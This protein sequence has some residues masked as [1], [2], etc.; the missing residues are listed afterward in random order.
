MS[1]TKLQPTALR[2]CCR[3]QA[4]SKYSHLVDASLGKTERRKEIQKLIEKNR[5]K[6]CRPPTQVSRS[7]DEL[8]AEAC[9]PDAPA[10][11]RK[12]DSKIELSQDGA[13]VADSEAS[14]VS[15]AV[16]PRDEPVQPFP[17]A[18]IALQQCLVAPPPIL[19][20]D[21]AAEFWHPSD[22]IHSP[23][24]DGKRQDLEE[25]VKSLKL[26]HD[27]KVKDLEAQVADLQV[28]LQ[29]AMRQLSWHENVRDWV[30]SVGAEVAPE[31]VKRGLVPSYLRF[32][33]KI[34]SPKSVNGL[35]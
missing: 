15:L 25:Q 13:A 17:A 12:E 6:R 3:T 1:A 24:Q 22:L 20:H 33:G 30:S 19:E 18:A 35:P 7:S 8:R 14:E 10:K 21:P 4:P 11:R 32:R 9:C 26:A 29:K 16:V 5:P 31:L 34:V 2:G 23:P 27:S 28:A